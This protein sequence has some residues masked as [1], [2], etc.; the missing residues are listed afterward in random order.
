[1]AF[2]GMRK[3]RLFLQLG[4]DTF[5]VVSA[6]AP[7]L[8]DASWNMALFATQVVL[9]RTRRSLAVASRPIS[10]RDEPV[11]DRRLTKQR[12]HRQQCHARKFRQIVRVDKRLLQP[13][14]VRLRLLVAGNFSAQSCET[15]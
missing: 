3:R 1:V 13:C 11:A 15:S 8:F 5:D 4:D 2:A 6:L 9:C 12:R 14:D 10:E 7:H